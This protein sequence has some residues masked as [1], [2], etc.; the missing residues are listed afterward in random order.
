MKN[1]TGWAFINRKLSRERCR[2]E[3]KRSLFKAMTGGGHWR[4]TDKD[5]LRSFFLKKRPLFALIACS[6]EKSKMVTQGGPTPVMADLGTAIHDFRSAR[7]RPVW[8]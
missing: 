7:A 4:K 1:W 5:F 8:S 3:S 2:K 6:L